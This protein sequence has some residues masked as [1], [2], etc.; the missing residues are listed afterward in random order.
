[1]R[2]ARDIEPGS[3]FLW[4]VREALSMVSGNVKFSRVLPGTRIPLHC[5]PTNARLRLHLGLVAAVGAE[6]RIGDET[7]E[8]REGRVFV[9]DDS[10]EH[11]VSAGHLPTVRA[12]GEES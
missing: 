7:L 11:E 12:R 6:L 5:G 2:R 9:F 4:Q 3:P 1:L 10:F 8:W